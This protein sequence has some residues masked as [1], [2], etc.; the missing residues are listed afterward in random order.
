MAEIELNVL[1]AQCMDRRIAD[2]VSLKTEVGAWN[3]ERNAPV[4][5]H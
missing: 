5:T 1:N 3:R 4:T 2:D